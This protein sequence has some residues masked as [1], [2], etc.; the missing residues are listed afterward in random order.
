MPDR[1]FT[2]IRKYG[3]FN[4][5]N[6]DQTIFLDNIYIIIKHLKMGKNQFLLCINTV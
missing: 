4:Q 6:F 3:K 2:L 1:V 5:S